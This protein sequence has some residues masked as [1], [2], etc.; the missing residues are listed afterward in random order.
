MGHS[1]YGNKP[2]APEELTD[3][4]ISKLFDCSLLGVHFPL[5]PVNFLH[6]NFSMSLGNERR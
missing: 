5:A 1:R 2:N 3:K 6:L 4:D